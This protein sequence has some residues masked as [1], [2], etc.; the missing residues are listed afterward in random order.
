M[1]KIDPV[2]LKGLKDLPIKLSKATIK[3]GKETAI[4]LNEKVDHNLRIGY[5][6]VV[7]GLGSSWDPISDMRYQ[8]LRDANLLPH[9][10]LVAETEQLV[11]SVKLTEVANDGFKVSVTSEYAET[12]EYGGGRGKVPARPYFY[13]AI[14]HLKA[15]K[16]HEKIIKDNIAEVIKES[17]K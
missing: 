7:E 10:G 3:S 6:E 1:I 14:N 12:H 5:K 15:E 17:Q 16:S 11:G 8:I 9:E 13:P 4:L 2:C